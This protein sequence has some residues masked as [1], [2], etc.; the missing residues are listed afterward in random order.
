MSKNTKT[1]ALAPLTEEPFK[2]PEDERER[3]KKQL[4]RELNRSRVVTKTTAEGQQNAEILRDDLKQIYTYLQAFGT[5]D[6]DVMTAQLNYLSNIMKLGEGDKRTNTIMGLLYSLAP[7][8]P[9]EGMLA[10]QIVA[11]N[12]VAMRMLYH[13]MGEQSLESANHYTNRAHKAQNLLLRQLEAFHA[14]QNGGHTTQ[15]VVVERVE[16]QNGGQAI[17]GVVA[18]GGGQN[19]KPEA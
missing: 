12:H 4:D 14:M 5:L 18:G 16:V 1:K 6:S 3:V 7:R 13:S 15:K 17:V 8:S 2:L 9:L 19:K 11:T 10:A